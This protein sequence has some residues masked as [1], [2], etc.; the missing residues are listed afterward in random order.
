MTMRSKTNWGLRINCEYN[1]Q[2]FP[3]QH[4]SNS[5]TH[6]KKLVHKKLVVCTELR[7]PIRDRM[8]KI[9]IRLS[10]VACFKKIQITAIDL[11]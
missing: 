3:V 4:C 1:V 11:S 10:G 6:K 2:L 9:Q 8:N 5:E 7:S